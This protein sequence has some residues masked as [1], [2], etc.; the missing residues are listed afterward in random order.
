MR[1]IAYDRT[2]AVAYARRWA[3]SRN[4]AYYDFEYIG[5]DCTNFASQCVYAGAGIMNYTPVTGWFYR[6]ASDRTASWTG[7]EYFW[8]FMT[9]NRS[10]GPYGREV[11]WGEARPGDVVQ[12]GHANGDY[13]H[14][15]VIVATEPELLVAAHSYDALDRPLRTYDFD[16]L[17]F[18]HIEGVRVW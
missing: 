17:R 8:K 12:L 18:L 9:E 7:V 5:G 13:Y 2:A 4:R 6:S 15:P 1:E 16:T 3:L 14:S 10:A 11:S